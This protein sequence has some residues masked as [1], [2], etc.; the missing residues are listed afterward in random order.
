MANET[1]FKFGLRKQLVLFITVVALVTYSTSGLFI[2]VL[3]PLF[4]S[5][6]NQVMFI[7]TTLLLGIV[8]SG[9]LAY[10]MASLII[11][12]LRRLEKIALGAAHG[13]ISEEVELAKR[14]DEIRSLGIAFNHM[15]FN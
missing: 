10:F 5:G 3:Y 2:F 8:W 12:P 9:I 4:F 6:W 1:H 14:D 15:L 13:N 11:K 7:V